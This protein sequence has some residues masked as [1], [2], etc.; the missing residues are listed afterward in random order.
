MRMILL[1]LTL[2]SCTTVQQE[3]STRG[4]CFDGVDNDGDALVDCEDPSCDAALVCAIDAPDDDTGFVDSCV[5]NSIE[6]VFPDHGTTNASYR[7]VI[8]VRLDNPDPAA[9]LTV[10][11]RS[12]QV[13]GSLERFQDILRLTPLEPLEPGTD[14]TVTTTYGEG[15]QVVTIFTTSDTGAPIGNPQ[16]LIGKTFEVDLLAGRFV[17]P[18]GVGSLLGEYLGDQPLFLEVEAASSTEVEILGIFGRQGSTTPEQSQCIGTVD[19]PS[20]EFTSNPY[21]EVLAPGTSTLPLGGSTVEI[22][23]LQMSSSFTP[24]GTAMQGGL[25]AG[26]LDTRPLVELVEE[27]GAKD[28]IC[29]LAASIG[30]DCEVCPDGEPLCITMRIDDIPAREVTMDVTP[31]PAPYDPCVEFAD[32][33]PDECPA[34]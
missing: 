15:C 11:G 8:E 34:Q 27:G 32:Q 7:T 9:T 24:E 25:F 19:F 31:R 10:V 5:S 4:D 21:F 3:G 22:Y 16:A 23:D 26:L 28:A 30:V 14:H 17:E 18:E 12:G 29:E 1:F 6:E 13:A 20:G 2:M 33:C